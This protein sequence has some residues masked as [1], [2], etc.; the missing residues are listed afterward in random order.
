MKQPLSDYLV[1]NDLFLLLAML[2]MMILAV[3]AEVFLSMNH[4]STVII[5]VD[6][7]EYGQYDLSIDQQIPVEID[8]ITCN[9]VKIK[10]NEAYMSFASCPDK[11]CM[12]QGHIKSDTQSIVCLPNRVIVSISGQDDPEIDTMTD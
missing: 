7:K 11:L 10:D 3:V 4:G 9:T 6:G 12:K 2:I 1:K 5:T 8:G